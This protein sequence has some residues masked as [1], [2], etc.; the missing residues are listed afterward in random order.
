MD[1][2]DA[3]YIEFEQKYNVYQVPISREQVFM[4]ALLDGMITEDQ[5][6]TARKY[7]GKLWRQNVK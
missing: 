4:S 6:N 3:M 5:F 7:F 1:N 2:F